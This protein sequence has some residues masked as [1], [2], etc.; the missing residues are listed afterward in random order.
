MKAPGDKFFHWVANAPHE[1]IAERRVT[2]MRRGMPK[3]LFRWMPIDSSDR[4]HRKAVETGAN[5]EGIR[6]AKETK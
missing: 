3:M 1:I 4:A 5:A 2:Y 6:K